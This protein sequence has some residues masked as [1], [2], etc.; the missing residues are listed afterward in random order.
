MSPDEDN[1]I[2][3]D[4]MIIPIAAIE[5]GSVDSRNALG[6]HAWAFSIDFLF[7]AV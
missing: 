2:S 3:T 7:V 4:L 6:F 1:R 5:D